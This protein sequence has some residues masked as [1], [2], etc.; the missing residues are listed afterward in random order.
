MTDK[1]RLT[2]DQFHQDTKILCTKIKQAGHFDKIIAVSRGGLFPAAIVAYELDIRQLEVINII[3][4]DFDQKLANPQISGFA[5]KTDKQTLI[6]DDLSDTGRSI[7]LLRQ[8]FPAAVY[9]VVYAKP[10]GLTAP[11]IYAKEIDDL[12]V[13]FPWDNER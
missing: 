3:G 11:D 9:A 13:V 7:E 6:I 10:Q 1:L 12:W 4:Y 2:W 8:R 5:G